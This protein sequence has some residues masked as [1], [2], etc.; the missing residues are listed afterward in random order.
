MERRKGQFW[1]AG[2]K[3]GCYIPGDIA[4][5]CLPT[6]AAACSAGLTCYDGFCVPA[7]CALTPAQGCC[8]DDVVTTCGDGYRC[9]GASCAG[10]R[11]GRCLPIPEGGRC[12]FDTDCV[13]PDGRCLGAELVP[14]DSCSDPVSAFG[15][16]GTCSSQ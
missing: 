14:V 4:G 9:Y 11:P 12:W 3:F 1:N 10:E 13:F 6:C 16:P 8:F 5:W 2:I 7:A 15:E